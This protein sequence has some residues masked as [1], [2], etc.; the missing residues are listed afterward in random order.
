MPKAPESPK[1]EKE[2]LNKLG[3]VNQ[4]VNTWLK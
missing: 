4:T 2:M 1:V 3:E